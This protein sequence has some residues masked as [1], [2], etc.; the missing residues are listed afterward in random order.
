M[1]E[2]APH[3]TVLWHAANLDDAVPSSQHGAAP[4]TDYVI[5][6][7]DTISRLA[8]LT[9]EWERLAAQAP[10]KL[11]FST[12]RWALTWW[13]HFREE[14]LSV[15]DLL[16]A[17]AIRS[18]TGELVAVAPLMLTV[19][20]G[21]GPLGL[22]YLQF[23]GADP[24]ITEVRGLVVHPDHERAVYRAL[25][26]HLH[27]W[28]ADWD[29][30]QW[31]GFRDGGG[32]PDE[33]EAYGPVEWGRTVTD[34]FLD[35]ESSWEELRAGLKPNIK[36]SL[37]KCYQSLSR[38]NLSYELE[39]VRGGPELDAA[40]SDLF[41]LHALRAQRTDTIAHKDVFAFPAAQRFL[42]DLCGRMAATGEL[43]L[44][45]LRVQGRVVAS[46]VGFAQ[47]DSLFLYYSGYDPEMSKYSVMTT[48][49]A[50]A[51]KYAI[52]QGFKR[53]NLSTGNDVSKTRWGPK[54]IVFHECVQRAPSLR[55]RFS[56]DAYQALLRARESPRLQK[57]FALLARQRA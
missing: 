28:Q 43:H 27:A 55:G 56:Y 47:G 45:R 15:R 1:L 11:P 26:S 8:A 39:V 38:E 50:E 40:L 2:T 32:G 30:L 16:F 25:L 18:R 14:T 49:V 41:R 24:N 21:R 5:E 10:V 4:L 37:R 54:E 12:P 42:R 19:R 46:R 3:S 34:Y 33:I 13:E 52:V 23:F 35:L 51:I 31:A 48:T 22:R 57:A 36:E 7:V 17:R 53:V 9:P 6:V 20:P 29:W 44:F